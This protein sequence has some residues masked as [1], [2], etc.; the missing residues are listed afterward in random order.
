MDIENTF[1][2]VLDC[3]F[4]VH[5][6]LG[7]GLLEKAYHKCLVYELNKIGLRV[8]SEKVLPLK[9]KEINIESGYRI[10]I[11][12]ENKIILELKAVEELTD[13]HLAQIITYMK[14]ANIKLGLLINFNKRYLKH[15]IKR[16]VL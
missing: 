13:T 9:Y 1:K 16:V 5:K 4:E 7:A 11:L 2:T 10:D 8:E 6:M 12:V 14:L 15:G 3:A